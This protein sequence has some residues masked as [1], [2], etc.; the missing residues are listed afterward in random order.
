MEKFSLHPSIMELYPDSSFPDAPKN[1]PADEAEKESGKNQEVPF[2]SQNPAKTDGDESGSDSLKK[3]TEELI[4]ALKE[5]EDENL[6]SSLFGNKKKEPQK[7]PENPPIS[8]APML[9]ILSSHAAAV[10]RIKNKRP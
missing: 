1:E 6:F 9:D 2:I 4:G 7:A 3:A 8:S 5:G 10:N